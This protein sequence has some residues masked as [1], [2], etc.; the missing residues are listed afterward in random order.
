MEEDE[1]DAT[2]DGCGVRYDEHADLL[3]AGLS[4]GWGDEDPTD[5]A[6]NCPESNAEFEIT[7][8]SYKEETYGTVE[9]PKC[10]VKIR[11]VWTKQDDEWT[12]EVDDVQ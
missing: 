1:E 12:S 4:C 11:L 6:P 7:G 2:C 5:W 3:C 8:V 9:C 10:K